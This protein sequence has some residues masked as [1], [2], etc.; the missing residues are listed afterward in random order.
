[1]KIIETK[2]YIE[3]TELVSCG[4]SE[5][6]LKDAKKRNS[7][8]WA[9][10]NDPADKRRVLVEYDKLKDNYK[11]LVKAKF[12][13]P[14]EYVCREPIK[15]MVKW[16]S[17]AEAWFMDYT[18]DGNKVLS[19]EHVRKYTQACNWL[20]MLKEMN[21]D[22][23]ALKK[24]L[25]I[26]IEEF[27]NHVIELIK[28][29][30]VDLPASYRRLMAKRKDYEERGYCTLIDPRF[31]NSNSTKVKDEGKDLL[32]EM[33]AHPNQYDDVY[34]A[35]Q[36]NAWAKNLVNENGKQIFECITSATVG[37]HRRANEAEI[38]TEREGASAF[39]GKYIKQVKGFRPTAP[40]YLVESDD[41]HLDLYFTGTDEEGKKNFNRYK[42]IVV[43]DSYNDYVLGYAYALELTSDVVKA[44]YIN[45]MYHLRE[46]TGAWHLPHEVKTDK[47]AIKQLEP[48]YKGMG[49]YMQSPVGSKHR[50][51]IEQFFGT[52]HWKRCL[53]AGA[54]NYS[55]N[56][57]SSKT[58]GVNMDVLGANTKFFPTVGDQAREQIEQFF[59][60]LRYMP[61]ANG[62]TKNEEWLEAW[63]CLSEEQKRPIT[64][65]QFLLKFGIEHNTND[66]G[67]KITNRGVEPRINGVKYSFDLET[68]ALHELIGKSVSV[69]YDP[70]DMS[71]V[72]VTDHDKIR[73][74]GREARLQSRALA[75][76]GV[77]SRMYLNQVF[78][79]KK[80]LVEEM[81]S[82]SE[83]RKK[84]LKPLSVNAEMALLHVGATKELKQQAEVV[85]LTEQISRTQNEEDDLLSFVNS[86]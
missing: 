79:E 62:K 21:T 16:D 15:Q 64:D 44:A 70:Y 57:I 5:N 67:I 42:A 72:L 74:I 28:I 26:S 55:G 1:M 38:L 33:I 25:N 37:V 49:K 29:E 7:K 78:A 30:K 84:R 47:W 40:L 32:L 41:N 59:H 63:Q 43:I 19:T 80:A 14:Y 36:Y 85:Y 13:N 31:G 52:P 86:F 54:N 35:Q 39:N 50:G 82:K 83:E 18:Y 10:I 46:L 58:R 27:N 12:G 61:Q 6:T 76:A 68:K 48:F 77:D 9:F 60:R 65:A 2:L 56:N 45:A 71:R 73:L 17:K 34:I 51:Y 11:E 66:K 22:K 4:V 20:N 69:F 3:F 81:A 24:L 75:D 23:R 53:K 8:S